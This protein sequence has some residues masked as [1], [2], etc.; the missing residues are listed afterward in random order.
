MSTLTYTVGVKGGFWPLYKRFTV[1]GHAV[2]NEIP[3]SPRL[4]L[5][6]PCGSAIIIPEFDRKYFKLYP[7]YHVRNEYA[8]RLKNG[9]PI[10]KDEPYAEIS[11]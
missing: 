10:I 5:S 8:K 6:L 3:G 11:E 9:A 2:N 1:V 7:D 4:A